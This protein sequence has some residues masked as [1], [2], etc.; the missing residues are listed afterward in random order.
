MVLILKFQNNI[1]PNKKQLCK[2]QF[3]AFMMLQV[4]AKNEK[5]IMFLYVLNNL[6]KSHFGFNLRSF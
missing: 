5:R 4:Y 6:R 2:R 1:F 3:R